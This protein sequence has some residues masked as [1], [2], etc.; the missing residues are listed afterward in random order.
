MDSVPGRKD[1]AVQQAECP[2]ADNDCG[3]PD[4][5]GTQVGASGRQVA[6]DTGNGARVDP[7]HGRYGSRI[8]AA[9]DQGGVADSDARGVVNGHREC[10]QTVDLARRRSKPRI[11]SV[12]DPVEVKPP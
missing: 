3:I 6:H 1:P 12:V 8:A 5:H 2:T 7:L 9:E 4:G 11:A 10:T